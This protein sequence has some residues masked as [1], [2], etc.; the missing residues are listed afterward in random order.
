MC[1]VQQGL[2]IGFLN[3][4]VPCH[5]LIDRHPGVFDIYNYISSDGRDYGDPCSCNKSQVFKKTPCLLVSAYSADDIFLA[6][7]SHCQ[8]HMIHLDL[9]VVSLSYRR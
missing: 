2:A 1:M 7:R 3:H 4:Y 5:I 6:D 8:R 9:Y